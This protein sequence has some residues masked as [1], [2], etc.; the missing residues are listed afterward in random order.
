MNET[1]IGLLGLGTVGEGVAAGLARNGHLIAERTGIRLVLRAIADVDLARARGFPVDRAILTSDAEA[2]IRDPRCAI[3]VE[4]IGGTLAAR[5]LI[6][7]ALDLGKPVVTANKALLA[8]HG[9]E[10]FDRARKNNTGL[11]FEASVGGGIPIIRSL[12]GGLVANEFESIT[13]ILNG[14]CNYILTQMEDAGTPFKTVLAEAQRAGFAEA[15]PSL[16][17]DG[18]D[19]AHKACILASLAFGRAI[20]PAQIQTQGIREIDPVDIACAGDLG[21]RIKMLAVIRRYREQAEVSVHPALVPSDHVLASVGGVFNAILV[22]GDL[23]GQT[24]YYGR[25]AG[26]DPT[27]SS[28]IGD[29]A[30]A[31]GRLLNKGPWNTTG[32]VSGEGRVRLRD[33][34]ASRNR[35]YLRLSLR[36]APGNLA[37][38]ALI[39]GEH[40]ISLATVVQHETGR[41]EKVPVVLLTHETSGRSVTAAMKEIDALSCIGAPTVCFR[42]EDFNRN[43][44][45]AVRK[46]ARSS[47]GPTL[48]TQ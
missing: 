48:K 27:A 18:H 46:T 23:S 19:T 14:T 31:A 30:D 2:V 25:G 22:H 20:Q 36:D 24:L 15:D 41:G 26:R 43:K 1:G 12:Q 45:I 11:F 37:R 9:A 21:Y 35:Y 32:F 17:I 38:V 29:I 16:D 5:R 8:E 40:A 34:D 7:L 42:I 4:T 3:I 28:V 33:P 6:L 13:G 47:P 10:L 44:A 39:F